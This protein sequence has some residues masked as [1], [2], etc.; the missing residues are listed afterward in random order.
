MSNAMRAVL[1]V[2]VVAVAVVLLIALKDSD[3]SGN[4]S[5]S[6]G[7]DAQGAALAVP[8]IVVKNGGPVGGPR[9]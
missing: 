3:D 2:A 7:G 5:D 9:T 4:G 1:G 6:N 8:T